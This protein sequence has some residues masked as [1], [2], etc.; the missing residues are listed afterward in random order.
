MTTG[1]EHAIPPM[2]LTEQ[3]KRNEADFNNLFSEPIKDGRSREPSTPIAQPIRPASTR[4]TT[5]QDYDPR[6]NAA[7]GIGGF[8]AEVDASKFKRKNEGYNIHALPQKEETPDHEKWTQ[9]EDKTWKPPERPQEPPTPTTPTTGLG[10]DK[11]ANSWGLRDELPMTDE[12]KA[13]ARDKEDFSLTKTETTTTGENRYVAARPPLAFSPMTDEQKASAKADKDFSLAQ[14]KAKKSNA[15]RIGASAK[16]LFTTGS[17][18]KAAE[19]YGDKFSRLQAESRKDRHEPATDWG[20][21]Q[22]WDLHNTST[23][24]RHIERDTWADLNNDREVSA[25]EV[26]RI[27]AERKEAKITTSDKVKHGLLRGA[28][29]V[30]G[31]MEAV[32]KQGVEGR[33]SDVAKLIQNGHGFAATAASLA[34]QGGKVLNGAIGSVPFVGKPL[35]KVASGV[36]QIGATALTTGGQQIKRLATENPLRQKLDAKFAKRNKKRK[37]LTDDADQTEQYKKANMTRIKKNF[38]QIKR[39]RK[40]SSFLDGKMNQ[41]QRDN[42]ANDLMSASVFQ[43]DGVTKRGE[44]FAD[45]RA[46]AGKQVLNRVRDSERTANFGARDPMLRTKERPEVSRSPTTLPP[47]S[48]RI[49]KNGPQNFL[50]TIRALGKKSADQNEKESTKKGSN[51]LDGSREPRATIMGDESDDA[52]D[53]VW[54]DE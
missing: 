36:T 47:G 20:K 25:T 12:Q 49:S 9:N 45:I 7:R 14:P 26:E 6:G 8:A 35:A 39:T 42:A 34:Q 28:E 22:K 31:G 1:P 3:E 41:Q 40:G 38:E 43:E 19:K 46:N 4:A 10:F 21:T 2:A 29:A 44:K 54:F 17:P 53:N 11:V 5:A 24:V 50:G 51:F 37:E 18:R 48:N 15:H 33:Q 13:S 16:R 30:G 52:L 23:G 32:G 27:K